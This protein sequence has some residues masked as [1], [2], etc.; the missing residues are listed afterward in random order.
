[1]APKMSKLNVFAFTLAIPL[2]T[3]IDN[4]LGQKPPMGWRSWN[5]FGAN[6]NQ[7]LLQG[8]MDGMVSKARTVDGVPTSL[9][10]LG[11]CDVGL[12]DNW[13]ECGAYGSENFTYHA[14]NVRTLSCCETLL[15]FVSPSPH[16]KRKCL[17]QYLF[18]Y[19][20]IHSFTE[21]MFLFILF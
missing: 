6:V 1:M 20:F 7:D 13:Q 11:Y 18:H 8:I 17:F 9:C 21:L 19:S 16:K 10:D 3:A 5:L 4:G 14:E 15:Y 12:D 2:T